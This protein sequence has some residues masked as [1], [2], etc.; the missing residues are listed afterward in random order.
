MFVELTMHNG[1]GFI[2]RDVDSIMILHSDDAPRDRIDRIDS[3]DITDTVVYINLDNV[4][5]ILVQPDSVA[6]GDDDD[7]DFII[8]STAPLN[9]SEDVIE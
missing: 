3:D 2:K 9:D 4:A 6:I 1:E 8:V 7:D 5:A